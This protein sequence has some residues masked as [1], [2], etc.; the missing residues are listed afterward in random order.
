MT[1]PVLIGYIIFAVKSFKHVYVRSLAC[2][3]MVH[4][5]FLVLIAFVEGHIGIALLEVFFTITLAVSLM[6]GI[7]EDIAYIRKKRI[8]PELPKFPKPGPR[9][10]LIILA[11]ALICGAV[12]YEIWTH[13]YHSGRHSSLGSTAV[14]EQ[15][16]VPIPASLSESF[17]HLNEL[18]SPED[19][20]WIKDSELD[21]LI[22][23]HFS[24]G[25][26]MRNHWLNQPNSGI[27]VE[28]LRMGFTNLDGMSQFIIEAYHHYLN[29]MDYASSK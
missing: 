13:Q 5:V 21:D 16:H 11:V 14:E 12:A 17:S 6:I 23:L 25:M 15:P 7:I 27:T 10:V 26:W 28:L 29:D 3:L 22:S 18:L 8:L 9:L 2:P 24:L 20:E 19:I 4:N 1:I